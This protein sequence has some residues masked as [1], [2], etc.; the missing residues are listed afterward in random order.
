MRWF[1]LLLV[2]CSCWTVSCYDTSSS[3]R[4]I[5]F[6]NDCKVVDGSGAVLSELKLKTGDTVRWCNRSTGVVFIGFST[7]KI[8][9][10]ATSLRLN[11]G[12]CVERRVGSMPYGFE[13]EWGFSCVDA[14]GTKTGNGGSPEKV[15]NPPPPPPGG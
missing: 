8:L 7:H 14:S 6:N 15:D 3:T 10:G 12:E 2:L 4:E 9:S 11:P 13:Y 1:W 5:A